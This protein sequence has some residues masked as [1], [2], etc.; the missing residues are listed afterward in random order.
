MKNLLRLFLLAIAIGGLPYTGKAQRLLLVEDLSLGDAAKADN[1]KQ[2]VVQTLTS[3]AKD[4]KLQ[5]FKFD[6]Q[7]LKDSSIILEIKKGQRH[8]VV[9]DELDFRSENDFTWHGHVK[10][11]ESGTAVFSFLNGEMAGNIIIGNK[12][13]SLS[14]FDKGGCTFYEID[15][16]QFPQDHPESFKDIDSKSLNTT[17]E[18]TNSS[19]N[20]AS[21][22]VR[23]LV[24]FTSS[25]EIG[26]A[27][28]GYSDMK[29]FVQQ[30]VA[31]T[32][33]SFINS[34]VTHRIELAAA[35]RVSYT[36]SGSYDTDIARF[37]GTNDG[38]MDEVHT[39]RTL[40]SGDM[41]V[42]I[43]NNGAYCGQASTIAATASTAFC[44]VHYDCALGYYSFG[45]E[46]GHLY[47]CRHDPAAD[48]TNTPYP[49]GHGYCYGPGGWRTI[50]SYN[51]CNATRIQ[52]W[53]NPNVTYGGVP[54]GTTTTHNNARVLNERAPTVAQF[55]SLPSSLT[56]AGG[57]SII[58]K[59][60]GDA[61]A[62]LSITFTP[63]FEVSNNSVFSAYISNGSNC[64]TGARMASNESVEVQ[65]ANEEIRVYPN[66]SA[67]NFTIQFSQPVRQKAIPQVLDSY[68]RLI[69]PASTKVISL[70]EYEIDLGNQPSGLYLV[71]VLK[72]KGWVIKKL[73]LTK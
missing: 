17:P 27:S 64:S 65:D 12:K 34:S 10:G 55:V 31:E 30:A 50:M 59:E 16:S 36:E 33:Q 73:L 52:Y 47:G 38:Y 29:L 57:G 72:E 8:V 54:M 45:H 68:G 5:F 56:M 14:P 46:L 37:Q 22:K 58:N 44:V 39:Y 48:P 41:C 70:Q 13:Y 71:R 11:Q 25:G 42:L 40:Y 24:A 1:Q 62:S 35:I 4:K 60:I 43:F 67:S 21:C 18:T 28:L 19:M 6:Q 66:P 2:R 7:V 49:Y 26:A 63:G 51:S 3:K 53:S 9:L 15:D 61:V 32:N 69:A 23:I 20:D